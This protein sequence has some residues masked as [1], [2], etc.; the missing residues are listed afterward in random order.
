MEDTSF[1]VD[2]VKLVRTSDVYGSQTRDGSQFREMGKLVN[3]EIFWKIQNIIPAAV[4]TQ[5][6]AFYSGGGGILGTADDYASY[7]MMIVNGGSLNGVQILKP[8]TVAIHTTPLI[9]DIGALQRAFGEAAR[10]MTFGG[11]Y[12]IKNEPD[13]VNE[14]D[15]Y[16]WAGAFNTFFWVDPYDGSAGV[17]LTSHWPVQYNISDRLE[18]IVDEARLK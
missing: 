7:L 17:F 3:S 10:Y 9:S 18:Q 2:P 8:E 11:G 15:Y 13:N 4:F 12:G 16:F 5:R 14:V 1:V 6:P